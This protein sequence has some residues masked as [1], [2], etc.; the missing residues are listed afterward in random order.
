MARNA[1]LTTT[2][3]A[4]LGLLAIQPWS[5]YELATQMDRSLGRI[6]PRATSKIYEEPKKLVVHGFARARDEATG[7]RPRTVYSITARGRRALAQWLRE[8]GGGP[9]LESEQLLKVFFSD[10]GTKADLLATLAAAHEWAAERNEGNV[11]AAQ[12]YAG[13]AGP[14]PARAAHTMLVGRFLTDYY[15]MVAEWAAWAQTQVGSWPDDVRAAVPDPRAMR[16]TL[17][18]ASW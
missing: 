13:S 3:Y 1:P 17:R 16:E 6:W 15:R 9:V 11:A 14:F 2:S 5:T 18:R 10:G 12:Q 7:A 4:I 8:P